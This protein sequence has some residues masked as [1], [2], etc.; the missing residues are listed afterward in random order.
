MLNNLAV[1]GR[2]MTAPLA[3]YYRSL[4]A[5]VDGWLLQAE[6]APEKTGGKLPTWAIVVIA[7]VAVVCLAVVCVVFILPLVLGPAIGNV[8]SG[9]QNGI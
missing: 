2:T 9:I 7:V 8:F 1:Y 5:R 3:E 4:Q 6:A